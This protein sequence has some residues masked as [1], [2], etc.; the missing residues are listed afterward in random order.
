MFPT[1]VTSYV[2]VA[3]TAPTEAV[4][5]PIVLILIGVD[6]T[7]AVVA[8]LEEAVLILTARA[9]ILALVETDPSISIENC[10]SALTL[11]LVEILAEAC[12]TAR[13]DRLSM[14]P[15]VLRLSIFPQLSN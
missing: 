10:I 7:E 14:L 4:V 12:K 2:A 11:A 8:I 5:A 6:V 13:L 9:L 15:K 1:T 3:D